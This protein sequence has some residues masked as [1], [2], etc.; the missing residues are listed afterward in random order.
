MRADAVTETVKFVPHHEFGIFQTL[1]E[2]QG[3][4]GWQI[5]T[6]L[7]PPPGIEP[8]FTV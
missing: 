5:L 8:G 3:F 4:G 1:Q 6:R 2:Q 7:V